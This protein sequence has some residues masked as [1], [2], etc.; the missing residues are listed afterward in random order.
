MKSTDFYMNNIDERTGRVVST[1][2]FPGRVKC[3]GCPSK[4]KSVLLVRVNG[5]RHHLCAECR[6]VLD[7]LEN[8]GA[9]L[10]MAG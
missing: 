6:R 8:Q 1:D 10:G 4:N 2:Y 9:P 3:E 5:T 7:T